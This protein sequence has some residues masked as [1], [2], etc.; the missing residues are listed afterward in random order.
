MA[1]SNLDIRN[2]GSGCL[3]W[4]G[5]LIDIREL[6]GGQDICIGIANSELGSKKKTKVLVLSL[7]VLIGVSTIGLTIGLYILI[8]TKTK[9]KKRKRKMNLKDDLEFPIPYQQ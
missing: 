2:G 8:K 6:P 5:D 7:S 3:L 4:Y 9:K 1:Y